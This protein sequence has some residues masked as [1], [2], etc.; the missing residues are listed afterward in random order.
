MP[1]AFYIQLASIVKS[2]GLAKSDLPG[3]NKLLQSLAKWEKYQPES[4]ARFYEHITQT[5]NEAGIARLHQQVFSVLDDLEKENQRPVPEVPKTKPPVRES[6]TYAYHIQVDNGPVD[7]TKFCI[8]AGQW[9]KNNC[10]T[11]LS[12]IQDHHVLSD[13]TFDVLIESNDSPVEVANSLKRISGVNSVAIREKYDFGVQDCT[14]ATLQLWREE[15]LP[16]PLV[17]RKLENAR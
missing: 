8:F 12:G 2:V 1:D 3:F 6:R 10:G 5:F 4:H 14:L 15:P 7:H 16:V 9:L 13:S 11:G 17:H